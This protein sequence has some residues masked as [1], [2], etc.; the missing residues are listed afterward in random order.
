MTELGLGFNF[1]YKNGHQVSLGM[2]SFGVFYRMKCRTLVN[3]KNLV[4]KVVIGP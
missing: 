2:I 4:N 1:A 3:W